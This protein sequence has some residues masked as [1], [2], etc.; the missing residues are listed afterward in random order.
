VALRAPPLW[1]T[2]PIPHANT[3]HILEKI[4]TQ[5]LFYQE[6]AIT[7]KSGIFPQRL[8]RFP[9]EKKCEFTIPAN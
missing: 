6:T 7:I 3:N 9:K 8:P 2:A 4:S 5:K 1:G